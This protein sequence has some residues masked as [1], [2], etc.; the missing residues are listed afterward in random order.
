MICVVVLYFRWGNLSAVELL[1]SVEAI[2]NGEART[3]VWACDLQGRVALHLAAE[4][5]FDAVCERL[6][7]A[8]E[9]QRQPVNVTSAG[10]K[11]VSPSPLK[12][13]VANRFSHTAPQDLTGSTPLGWAKRKANGRPPPSIEKLLFQPGDNSV[14][15]QSAFLTR[16]GRTPHKKKRE[17][18]LDMRKRAMTA[19]PKAGVKKSLVS[20]QTQGANEGLVYASSDALGWRPTME[21]RIVMKCPLALH[22]ACGENGLQDEDVDGWSM[23]GVMDGHGGDFSS[24]FVSKCLPGIV[25]G[26]LGQVE[27]MLCTTSEA[28]EALVEESLKTALFNA[29]V[30]SDALLSEQE[31]MKVSGRHGV[32]AREAPPSTEI[33]IR[34][35]SGTTACFCVIGHDVIAVANVGDSRAIMG[36]Y[37]EHS[38]LSYKANA[39]GDDVEEGERRRVVSE[40]LSEDHKF[41]VPG[42]R[43]RASREGFR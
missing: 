34:D 2:T 17:T 8:M 22:G 42:E 21:D 19:A 5:S 4:Y 39:E 30:Q 3:D 6:L 14:M 11:I 13:R 24:D 37:A 33:L 1:L 38:L 32:K 10:V 27:R 40:A 15:P 16:S 23:F 12:D 26:E 18:A 7:E 31:R 9:Q 28:S 36:R 29:C 41:E 35:V 43:G 25:A 20:P